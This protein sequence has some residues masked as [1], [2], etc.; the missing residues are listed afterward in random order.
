MRG[1]PSYRRYLYNDS[2]EIEMWNRFFTRAGSL[3]ALAVVALA[4]PSHVLAGSVSDKSDKIVLKSALAID[5]SKHTVTLPLYRGVYGGKAAWYIITDASDLN[6]ARKLHVV[7]SP[8]LAGLAGSAVQHVAKRGND[9]VFEGAPDFSKERTYVAGKAGF[10]PVSATPGGVGDSKYSPFIRMDGV[11][12]VLNAPI[13]ATG[14]TFDVVHHTN[15]EDCVVGIDTRAKTVT[16]LMIRGYVDGKLVDYLSTEASDPGGASASRATYT[17]KLKGAN[18]GTI[19][20]GVVVKGPRNAV[21]GQGLVYLALDTPLAADATPSNV[22]TIGSPFN[23]LASAPDPSNLYVRSAYSPLWAVYA[24]P[25]GRSARIKDYATFASLGPKKAG[26][27][28]NCP[29]IAFE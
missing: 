14:G 4:T 2:K 21:S 16:L 17:P 28:V 12:G 9:S 20:I 13:V 8:S 19:P 5:Y 27:V 26:F 24:L 15:T 3:A 7:F 6:Q 18:A 1:Y 29:V 23:I 10:P 22:S 25:Q 11:P